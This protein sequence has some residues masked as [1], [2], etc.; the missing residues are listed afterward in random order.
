V[1][2]RH[3]H[4]SRLL[5]GYATDGR[6][7]E[8]AE[9]VHQCTADYDFSGFAVEVFGSD[10]LAEGIAAHLRVIP[11]WSVVSGPGFQNTL[12]WCGLASGDCGRA[13][14]CPGTAFFPMGLIAVVWRPMSP[15][16]QS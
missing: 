1:P 14:P 4:L 9:A 10:A 3:L 15:V 13:G 16:L 6:N 11:A 12:Q 2:E 7:V 5:S 8:D